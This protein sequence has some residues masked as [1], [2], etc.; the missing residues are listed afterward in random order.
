MSLWFRMYSDVINDPKVLRL[1]DAMFR[2]W[3]TLL[4]IA[5]K[6]EGVLPPADDIS[7]MLR[8]KPSKVAEWITI[9]VK[10]ELID[11]SETGF[12]PHNWS[13]R[14]Y[15]SDVSTE[16]VK[17]FREAKRN[18]SS[19]VTET[20]PEQKQSRAEQIDDADEGRKRRLISDAAS[21]LAEKLMMIA[22]HDP[23]FWPPGWCGAPLRVQTWLSQGWPPEVIEAAVRSA[24]ARKVGNPAESVQYFEKAIAAE[25]A[26]QAA[27]LPNV[28]VR[29]PETVRINRNGPQQGNIIQAA[30][31]LV[32]AVAS[33]DEGPDDDLLLRGG[34]GSASP[35][36]LSQG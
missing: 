3:V 28:E 9:L 17:R 10:A 32:S 30:D 19:A 31:R 11:R 33:F 22:G 4:A 7:L 27:P 23:A 29:Q 12:A 14:Q 2:A 1:S 21:L 36:L 6:N 18:V 8:L 5:A 25:V 26:R 35:R 34:A 15:K 16:R 20:A 13:T 24:A